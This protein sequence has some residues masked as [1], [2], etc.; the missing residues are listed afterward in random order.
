[1][2]AAVFWMLCTVGLGTFFSMSTSFGQTYGPLAG[3]VALLLWSLLS[4]ISVL[5]GAAFAAQLEA[6][7]AGVPQPQDAEKV[8]HSEPDNPRE[9]TGARAR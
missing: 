5:F 8:E 7:R 9:L 6:V 1:M 3:V 4:A 2:I